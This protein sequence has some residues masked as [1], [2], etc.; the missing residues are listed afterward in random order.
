MSALRVSYT[1]G[2][3]LYT[4]PYSTS[5]HK[6]WMIIS[7][8]VLC[9]PSGT[10]T[11]HYLS[12][13]QLCSEEC[14]KWTS[15]RHRPAQGHQQQPWRSQHQ[16]E[17]EGRPRDQE[18]R[19]GNSVSTPRIRTH[20]EVVSAI[21]FVFFCICINV[22]LLLDQQSVRNLNAFI[23]V[24]GFMPRQLFIFMKISFLLENFPKLAIKCSN[25]QQALN[26]TDYH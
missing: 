26:S 15:V 25:K 17:D 2:T 1:D 20:S 8:A 3:I 16:E 23:F 13:G 4:V 14:S 24:H 6:S 12:R 9:V 10:T 22:K 7:V 19:H 5:F 11:T 21:L 18:V